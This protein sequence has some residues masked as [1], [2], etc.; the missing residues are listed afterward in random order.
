[1]RKATS[2]C[3]YSRSCGGD[4]GPHGTARVHDEHLI[5]DVEQ[6]AL[7]DADRF[8]LGLAAVAV[9]IEQ[10]SGLLVVSGLG[11]RD[12]VDYGVEL[13]VAGSAKPVTF[14]VARPDG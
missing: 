12:A 2:A 9:A 5:D 1:V 10:L 3:S 8:G 11:N 14:T 4:A 6:S 13:P 7:E